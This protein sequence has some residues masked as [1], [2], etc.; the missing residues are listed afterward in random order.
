MLN[1]FDNKDCYSKFDE[2]INMLLKVNRSFRKTKKKEL[3]AKKS[4][5]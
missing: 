3:F 1:Y 4:Y 5:L 2:P